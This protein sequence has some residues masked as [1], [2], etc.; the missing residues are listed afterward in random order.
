[1]P[2]GAHG[3]HPLSDVLSGDGVFGADIDSTI[4]ELDALGAWD[5]EIAV[6][7]MLSFH[8][9]WLE[10]RK[11]DREGARTL[12]S[13]FLHTLRSERDRLKSRRLSS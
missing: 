7:L 13:N 10:V 12:L 8:D 11:E 2:N 4:R 5:S 9:Q 1:M 6:F 3:D